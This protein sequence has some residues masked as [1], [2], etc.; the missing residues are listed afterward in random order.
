M[1]NKAENSRVLVVDDQVDMLVM[2]QKVISRKCGGTTV[3]ISESAEKALNI[4]DSW[5]PD[6]VLT[7]IKMAGMDGIEFLHRLKESDPTTTEPKSRT[8]FS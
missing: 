2:L 8:I 7:D 1:K 6:V 5:C 3:R 4:A